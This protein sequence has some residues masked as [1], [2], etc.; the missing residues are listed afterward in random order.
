MKKFYRV[1]NTETQQGLWYDFNGRFTGLIHEDFSFC[2]NNSLKMD[3]D[4]ELIGY[5]SATELLE[6]LW[7]WFTP[8]DIKTLQEFGWYIH[9]YETDDYKFYDKF[10]HMVINQ[11]KSR[12]IEK[13]IL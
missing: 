2:K 12:L 13:I 3:Y 9:V 8:D 6:E 7:N 10:K 11:E 4:E 5:L 1:C